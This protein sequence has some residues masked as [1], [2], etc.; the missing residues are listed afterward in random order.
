MNLIF[1]LVV[2][3]DIAT[4]R[5]MGSTISWEDELFHMEQCVTYSL[6]FHLIT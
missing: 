3:Q 4:L 2:I 1:V 6:F 5:Q